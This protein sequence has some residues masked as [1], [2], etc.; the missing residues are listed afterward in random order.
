MNKK[1]LYLRQND[2]DSKTFYYFLSYLA[3]VHFQTIYFARSDLP[4]PEKKFSR[5][6]WLSNYDTH[7]Q[8]IIYMPFFS[9]FYTIFNWSSIQRCDTERSY[10]TM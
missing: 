5:V 4:E 10:T 3:I 7:R 9:T 1:K 2:L 8:N 6:S